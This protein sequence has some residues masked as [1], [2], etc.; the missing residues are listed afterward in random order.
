MKKSVKSLILY[1]PLKRRFITTALPL[2][3]FNLKGNPGTALLEEQAITPAGSG[4]TGIVIPPWMVYPRKRMINSGDQSITVSELTQVI[5]STLETGFLNLSVKGEISNFRPSSTGHYYFTLKDDNSVISVVMFRNRQAGLSFMPSDGN[6]VTIKGDLSVYP[7]RGSYQI[8]CEKMEK[9]GSGD[10]LQLLEKRKKKLASEGLF[11]RERKKRLPFL[12]EK[13]ILITSPTGAALR[14]ILQVT[15]R[16]CSGINIVILPVPVQGE[17]ASRKIAESIRIANRYKMGDVII[18]GRGGGSLEDLLPFS[19]EEVVYAI[20]NS[21]IPVISAVGHEIDTALSDL[22]ADVRAPTP[23]SAAEIV[24]MDR[25]ELLSRI[26]GIK[27]S[28][29]LTIRQRIGIV[30]ALLTGFTPEQMERNLRIIIQPF[31]L[32]FDDAKE[33][34]INSMKNRLL[35]KKHM[36]ELIK[37]NLLS[38]SPFEILKKGYAIVT[39][40]K[41]NKVITSSTEIQN[42]EM[43]GIRLDSGK[44]KAEVK[45]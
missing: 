28:L 7:K 33:S 31:L 36:V 12:P 17:K 34:I 39:D 9:S 13:V 35:K 44:L 21:E 22:A 26:A 24:S 23:S 40:Y 3:K 37:Q 29:I 43:I 30:R 1:F 11:D 6:L 42:G 18:T 25:E 8:I 15:G 27:K 32:R 2:Y 10:I 41:T 4:R 38:S 45:K 20:A 16:R 14:D 19:E 5:R